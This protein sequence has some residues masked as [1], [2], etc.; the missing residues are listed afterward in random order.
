MRSHLSLRLSQLDK[1]TL[2]SWPNCQ[3]ACHSDPAS[4]TTLPPPPGTHWGG[5]D[6]SVDRSHPTALDDSEDDDD[7]EE[8]DDDEK[9]EEKELP[10]VLRRLLPYEWGEGCLFGGTSATLQSSW[11]EPHM[12]TRVDATGMRGGQL[13]L[14]LYLTVAAEPASR[15]LAALGDPA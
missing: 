8:D 12:Y 6:G 15:D 13:Q 9:E 1:H 3:F 11:G 2:S 14:S 5:C 7:D 4:L 10:S